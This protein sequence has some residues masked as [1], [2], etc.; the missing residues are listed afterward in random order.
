MFTASGLRVR[1]LKV[2]MT[3]E[4]FSWS[5]CYVGDF[6]L[7]QCRCEITSHGRLFLLTAVVCIVTGLGEKWLQHC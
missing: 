7:F 3:W 6:G 2:S 4:F 1:F 5:S